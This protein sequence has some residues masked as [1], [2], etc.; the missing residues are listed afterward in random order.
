[1]KKKIIKILKAYN[2]QPYISSLFLLIPIVLVLIRST[3]LD[4]D[5]WFILALGKNILKKGFT[6]VEPLSMHQ[7]LRYLPQQWASSVIFYNTYK[8]LGPI[9]LSIILILSSLFIIYI[10]YKIVMLITNNKTNLAI[11]SI[12]LPMIFLTTLSFITHRPQIFSLILILMEIHSLETYVEQNNPKYLLIILLLSTCMV[13]MHASNFIMIILIIIP[14]II[15]AIIKKKYNPLPLIITLIFIPVFGLINPYGID[16]ITYAKGSFSNTINTMIIEMKNL[17]INNIFGIIITLYILI[18]IIITIYKRKNI[19]IRFFLLTI[20]TLIMTLIHIKSFIYFAP[21]SSISISYFLSKDYKNPKKIPLNKNNKTNY[22]IILIFCI[23]L[24]TIV[25]IKGIYQFNTYNNK[26]E[27]GINKILT[28]EKNNNN[29]KVSTNFNNGG[30]IEFRGLKSYIDPRAEVYLKSKN[31]RKDIIEEYNNIKTKKDTNIK[32]FIERYNFDYF[33]EEKNN[34]FID[35]Y[36]KQN[37]YP[38]IY[39]DKNYTIYKNI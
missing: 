10:I 1:M 23:L 26:L 39:E 38:I 24:S 7:G 25:T 4:N 19:N 15:E 35:Y 36:L 3:I 21:I 13:N 33:V 20:G 8:L 30:Y 29:I 14:Y 37:N 9:G 27:K 18:I 34:T 5:I 12:T 17:S 28:I 2:P 22:I 31:R 6:I 11:I 32:K 16:A